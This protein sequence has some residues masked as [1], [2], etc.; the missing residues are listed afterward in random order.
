M[1]AF[2]RSLKNVASSFSC[3]YCSV[4]NHQSLSYC[5]LESSIQTIGNLG[6]SFI[7]ESPSNRCLERTYSILFSLNDIDSTHSE[8]FLQKNILSES[9]SRLKVLVQKKRSCLSPNSPGFRSL[10]GLSQNFM[11]KRL[12]LKRG[13]VAKWSKVLL[14]KEKT[15]DPIFD[16]WPGQSLKR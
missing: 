3:H 5:D 12:K 13:A 1:K 15:K 16:H 2:K 6:F 8:E 4:V 11:S 10:S 7:N 14:Q 9:L